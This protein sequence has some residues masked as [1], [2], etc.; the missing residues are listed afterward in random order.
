MLKI[1]DL[2]PLNLQEEKIKF[3]ASGYTYNPHF[4]YEK[5]VNQTELTQYGKP[6]WWPLMQ[7]KW[8]AR[9]DAKN[10]LS[11][12]NFVKSSQ[13]INQVEF[14]RLLED[15]LKTYQLENQ[16]EIVFSKQ[17]VSRIS[18]NLKTQQVKVQ[19]PIQIQRDEVA[20]VIAHEIE[21]HILRQENSKKQ[22]WHGKKKKFGLTSHM[23]TE[24][25]LA[26]ANE[27][28]MGGNTTAYKQAV[29]YIATDLA[30]HDSFA[31][32]FAF[33]IQMWGDPERAWLWTVKKKRGL[34]DTS[35]KGAFTKDVVYFEGLLK[36]LHYLKKNHYDPRGLY[37]GKI[38][39]DDIKKIQKLNPS[40]EILLPEFLKNNLA[41]YQE[42]AALLCKNHLWF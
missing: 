24:E 26:V 33:Y 18:V 8:I 34:T 17:F 16:Y 28:I 42:K 10:R 27:M 2:L 39:V 5:E 25:G 36:V 37:L 19:L 32:V 12:I 22:I 38:D 14:N 3:F 23:R 7:A 9:R 41:D 29:N 15:K 35:Q 31:R 11:S 40:K 6:R 30:L 20:A 1:N 4:V 21:T 13:F